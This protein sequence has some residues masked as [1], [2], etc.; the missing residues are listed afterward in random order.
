M[1][2]IIKLNKSPNFIHNLFKGS[3]KL[4]LKMEIKI[5]IMHNKI[6]NNE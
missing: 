4:D 3:N 2:L 1:G 6:K 5:K